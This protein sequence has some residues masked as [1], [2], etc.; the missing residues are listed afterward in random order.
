MRIT[1]TTPI[2]WSTCEVEACQVKPFKRTWVLV[3]ETAELTEL[4]SYPWCFA[5]HFHNIHFHHPNVEQC[6][7]LAF[8]LLF[9]LSFYI[10]FAFTFARVLTEAS[11]PRGP[12]INV[13]ATL[14]AVCSRCYIVIDRILWS[15]GPWASTF[16][17]ET[18]VPLSLP[19][20]YR[21]I[22]LDGGTQWRI[23]SIFFGL[24]QCAKVFEWSWTS[25]SMAHTS[26]RCHR[27]SKIKF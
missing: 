25:V 21:A 5:V 24:V 18:F 27:A 2:F 26:G 19:L 10:L 23:D 3:W 8:F 14:G 6:S 15:L 7:H 12:Y 22:M 11:W 16:K 4:V 13:F 17:P 1:L 20:G 9:L